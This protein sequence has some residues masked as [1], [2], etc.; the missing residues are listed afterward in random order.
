M[1]SKKVSLQHNQTPR[2]ETELRINYITDALVKSAWTRYDVVQYCKDTYGLSETQG[3]KYYTAAVKNIL[4]K[5]PEAYRETL[6]ARNMATL[7]RMLKK[8]LE[9]ENLKMADRIIRTIN[10]MLG[11]GTKDVEIKDKD[12]NGDERTITISFGE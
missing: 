4:P 10:S 9:G 8:S 12:S 1:A 2:L 7:E 3:E 11:V 6:I 5:N